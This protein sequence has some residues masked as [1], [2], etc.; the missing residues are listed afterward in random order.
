ML[1]STGTNP[2]LLVM[3]HPDKIGPLHARTKHLC[4]VHVIWQM[5]HLD[6]DGHNIHRKKKRLDG[7]YM[8]TGGRRRV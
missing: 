6:R 7:A 4:C 2:E 1:A 5:V 8:E 3:F